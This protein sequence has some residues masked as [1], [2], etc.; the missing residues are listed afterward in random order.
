MILFEDDQIAQ[1]C[2]VLQNSNR[3]QDCEDSAWYILS[4]YF[5]QT[6]KPELQ[7]YSDTFMEADSGLVQSINFLSNFMQEQYSLNNTD[8]TSN[9]NQ[10]PVKNSQV[11]NM[12]AMVNANAAS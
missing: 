10:T 12:L 3:L 11:A 1:L 8:T 2:N 9:T 6:L 5:E 7:R 4:T